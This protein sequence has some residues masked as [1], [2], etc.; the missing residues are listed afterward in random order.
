MIRCSKQLGIP[1]MIVEHCYLSNRADCINFL[2]TDAKIK[3]LA[4][5]DAAGIAENIGLI[6]QNRSGVNSTANI[7][8]QKV[9]GRRVYYD[10]DGNIKTGFFKVDGKT[11]FAK[12]NGYVV[13]GWQLINGSWYFFSA[14]GVMAQN[15]W[16]KNNSGGTSYLKSDGKMAIGVVETVDG[17]S[18]F[19]NDGV[20]QLKGWHKYNN[21]WYYCGSTGRVFKSRWL[22]YKGNMYYFRKNGKMATGFSIQKKKR[23]YLDKNGHRVYGWQKINKKWYYFDSNGVAKVSEFFKTKKKTYYFDSKGVM[24]TGV[25]KIGTD[26]YLFSNEGVL[27]KGWIKDG[28]Y[29]YFANVKGKLKAK[30]WFT[31]DGKKYYFDEYGRMAT[32]TK[33]IEGKTYRFQKNGVFIGEKTSTALH[34]VMSNV[35]YTADQM[36]QHFKSEGHVY[37]S[38]ALKEGGAKDL[39]TFCNIIVEEATAEGVNPGLVYAQ[40]MNETGWL[41]FGGDVKITQFN[42]C[43]MGAV[44]GGEP[45][46]S[47][48]DVR[49]GIRAQ[50]QHLKAYG[51][52]EPLKNKCVDPRFQ[53]V[54]RGCAIYIEHLGIQEN[55]KKKGWAS[56]VGYGNRLL[57][58][59]YSIK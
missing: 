18:L 39:K 5:A 25:T 4:E 6:Q 15:K 53:Y 29:W 50:V 33:V 1:G 54:E 56:A 19:D 28:S 12:S 40:I 2:Q 45:G 10:K 48:K 46:C 36:A 34:P 16:K 35:K 38:K 3:K 59:M 8:W 52:T 42:F 47:F 31:K 58:I 24:A 32:G 9:N 21:A 11:Y 26:L 57:N 23:Y 30:C 37:P 55:P 44:G 27:K 41:Q 17:L 43:G 7:G 51:S 22:K 20:L 49:T 14:K 13:T